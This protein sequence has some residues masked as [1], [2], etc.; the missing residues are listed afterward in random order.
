[1]SILENAQLDK[2]IDDALIAIRS[3]ERGPEDIFTYT[4]VLH[5]ATGTGSKFP[6]LYR[7]AVTTPFSS[8]MAEIGPD[9]WYDVLRRDPQ[10]EGI[11]LLGLDIIQAITQRAEE[12]VF[13]ATQALQEV[14]SDLY[15]GFLSDADREGVKSPDHG[16][17]A[18]LVKWGRPNF[19]PYVWPSRSSQI[20]G[21]K[22]GVVNLPPAFASGGLAA[23]AALGHE[24]SGHEIL[25]AD[26]GLHDELS[27]GVAQAIL[28]SGHA[29]LANQ[30]TRERLAF[31]WS[32]RI[33]ETASDVM[34]IVNMGPCAAIGLIAY[35][36]ALSEAYS[37][38]RKLSSQAPGNGPHPA[39]LA[40]A[41]I[42]AEA[43]KLCS[44]DQGEQWRDE[45][46]AEV[47]KDEAATGILLGD[48]EFTIAEVKAAAE[49][50]TTAILTDSQEAL[51]DHALIEIQDWRQSDQ[52]I[53]EMLAAMSFLGNASPEQSTLTGVYAAHV[54]SAAISSALITGDLKSSHTRMVEIAAAMHRHN[55]SWSN[56]HVAT[57]GDFH[58][59]H[60][61]ASS[62]YHAWVH[63]S[64]PKKRSAKKPAR[65]AKKKNG[66][67]TPAGGRGGSSIPVLLSGRGGS[68][69]PVLL[70]DYG[71]MGAQYRSCAGKLGGVDIIVLLAKAG[72]LPPDDALQDGNL[73]PKEGNENAL[74]KNAVWQSV[75]EKLA[76]APPDVSS[77]LFAELGSTLGATH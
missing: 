8:A 26:E 40:R 10:L 37:G 51:Q 70:S 5:R 72:F 75:T 9:G 22:A 60:V 15:D 61:S 23:W 65:Q 52:Q 7:N 33:D 6:A 66:A 39:P 31:Y 76:A 59:L 13:D 27:A 67:S 73:E 56:L 55:P 36:R 46:M 77:L 32:S 58:G 20:Y 50:V 1:M 2:L 64:A 45:I 48:H 16:V 14:V 54:V 71:N 62:A 34:G 38:E 53:V 18:P 42:M 3:S 47:A 35:F 43:L 24:T 21:A 41:Y 4:D 63:R 44:F 28:A 74:K 30:H 12:Y 17:A 68:S 25:H 57:A 11:G 69:I 29:D 19:G 49:I